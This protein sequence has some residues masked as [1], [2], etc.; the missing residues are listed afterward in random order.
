MKHYIGIDN[1]K[2]THSVSIID[3][4]GNLLKTL[5]IE[6]DNSGFEKLQKVMSEYE[7][8]VIAF[9]LPHGP[10][11][12]YLRKLP[13]KLFSLNPLKVKRFKEIYSVSKDK[14]DKVDSNAIAQYI[15][16]NENS[17]RELTF[18]SPEIE[19][20]KVLG[21]SH[22]RLTKDHTRYTLR[23]IFILRQ[24]FPLYDDLFC[25]PASKISLKMIK[26]YPTYSDLI[27]DS[28]ENII[29]FL[30]ANKYRNQKYI[31]RLLA[32]I[33]S[34]RHCIM[35]ETEIA[36]S[37]EAIAIANILLSLKDQLALI[38]SRMTEITKSHPIG[39]IFYSLPGAGAILSSKLLGLMGDNKNRFTKANQTQSLFGTAP[40]NYQS[41]GYHKVK[42]RKA[43]N[44]RGK[45]ILYTF[46]F[47]SMR[48]SKWAR[49]YYDK[50]RKLGKNHSVAVRALSNKWMKIIFAMWKNNSAYNQEKRFLAVA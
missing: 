5:D 33:K 23:L 34:Y 42:M 19:T 47:S 49:E 46:A 9:E 37:I 29:C 40:I 30:N 43:C 48:F 24:Y 16:M 17:S 12:D 6:N 31:R 2:L 36:L 1:S 25:E 26:R 3:S 22:E 20:L 39:K 50:Q 14:S 11:V 10:I 45:T 27:S 18:N 15:R 13:Y 35:P 8:P 28:D 21:I 32:K 4:N 38:E 44:K 41:G 7:N